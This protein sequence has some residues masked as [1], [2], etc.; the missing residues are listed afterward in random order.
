[1][2]APKWRVGK[3]YSFLFTPFYIAREIR[4]H[5]RNKRGYT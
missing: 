5:L 2:L 1:M 4:C 3:I